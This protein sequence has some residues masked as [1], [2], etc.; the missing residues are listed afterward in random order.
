[1]INICFLCLRLA[2]IWVLWRWYD[3]SCR[4]S[5]GDAFGSR[6]VDDID[7]NVR[8]SMMIAM[9]ERRRRCAEVTGTSDR[10]MSRMMPGLS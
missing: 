5:R 7:A 8:P 4:P 9:C 2:Y 3:L 10:H 1:M 6:S